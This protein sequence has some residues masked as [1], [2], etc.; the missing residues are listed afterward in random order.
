M[1][2]FSRL[3]EG[4]AK[5]RN[6][7]SGI[8]EH[9]KLVTEEFYESIED[10][11][12]SADL[13][14][15][16]SVDVVERLRSEVEFDNVTSTKEAY[17]MLKRVLQH[18]LLVVSDPDDFPPKPWTI[19]MIG[20]NGVGKTTTIGKIAKEYRQ[21]GRSVV[22]AAADTFRAGATEQ[23]RVWADRTDCDFVAQHEGAD[24]AS[25][26]FDGMLAAKGRGH[27]VMMIDT[28]GRL[29]NKKNLMIELDKIVRVLKKANPWTPN[30]VLLVVDATTGQNAIKQAE[31][32]NELI[33][34]TGFVVTKLDGTAKGGVAIALTKKFGIPVRKIGVGEGVED[35]QDFDPEK[36][37]EAMFG[38]FDPLA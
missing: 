14:A 8:V 3:K 32:F 16:L 12:I 4:L 33:K 17:A 26:V 10:A 20:V 29:H 23:L 30:E 28:A 11:L 15:D 18:D 21:L 2:L 24:A 36:Y 19:L 25:V 22:L 6:Q 1:N 13:G 34:I 5:T 31:A 27:D 35:L 37:V 38:D 9:D 7:I